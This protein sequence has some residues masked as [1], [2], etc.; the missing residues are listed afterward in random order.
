M[1][2]PMASQRGG[3]MLMV[4]SLAAELLFALD[5]KCG[6]MLPLALLCT[7]S[8]QCALVMPSHLCGHL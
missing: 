8:Q 3:F 1:D 7:P 4:H 2:K 6:L 5:Q